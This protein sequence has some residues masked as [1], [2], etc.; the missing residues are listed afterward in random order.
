MIRSRGPPWPASAP[1]WCR[2]SRGMASTPRCG[3]APRTP[4]RAG[5][6]TGRRPCPPTWPRCAPRRSGGRCRPPRPGPPRSWPTRPGTA[7]PCTRRGRGC[8]SG[9]RSGWAPG[10][11]TR[12]AARW[13]S[14]SVASRGCAGTWT[15][16][17]T[18]AARL[19]WGSARAARRW[20]PN[21]SDVHH[22]AG[23]RPGDP[24]DGL[25]VHRDE[26]AQVVDVVR[27]GA[28]D[29][30]VRACDVFRLR[31]PGDLADLVGHVGGLTDF[32][33]DEDIRLHHEVLP[34]ALRDMGPE[35]ITL[36]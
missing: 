1:W 23:E 4:D 12:R 26:P 11:A 28:D 33:L 8:R 18:C 7:R 36:P 30:V 27:V 16:P 14:T 22:G 21:S 25:D 19:P 34:R 17:P 9:R 2:T 3:T 24:R 31:D 5:P 35:G 13:N 15:R 20:R 6:A 10:P 32:R 29:D